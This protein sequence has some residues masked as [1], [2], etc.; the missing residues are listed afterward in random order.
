M[1][2]SLNLE[3]KMSVGDIHSLIEYAH[4]FNT[5]VCLALFF[6]E[7]SKILIVY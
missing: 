7:G 1:K 6:H 5:S 3:S 4:S 2:F